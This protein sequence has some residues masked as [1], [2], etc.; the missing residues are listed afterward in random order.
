MRSLTPSPSPSSLPLAISLTVHA[1]GIAAGVVHMTGPHFRKERAPAERIVR[2]ALA[3]KPPEPKPEEPHPRAPQ[4]ERPRG[5]QVL[6]APAV[7]PTRLPDIT[8][9]TPTREEDFSGRGTEGGVADGVGSLPRAVA[10]MASG[11]PYDAELV[12]RRPYMLDAKFL[13]VYPED[14]RAQGPD[15]LVLVRF[16]LD[17]TGR[18]EAGTI[19]VV[20][21]THQLFTQAVLDILGDLRYSPAYMAH[22]KVRARVEQRFEFHLA[23]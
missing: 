16:V 12:D 22:R 10:H 8:L 21:T 4:L 13:P 20:S 6:V 11:E 19:R 23:K 14:L 1:L 2:I 9:T 7:V 17:T 3:A 18:I 5:F 15:G